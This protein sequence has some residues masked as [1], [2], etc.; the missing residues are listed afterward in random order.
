MPRGDLDA[1][2]RRILVFTSGAHFLTHFFVLVFPALYLARRT[3]AYL[4]TMN[5]G[6]VLLIVIA[7]AWAI[8]R[9][10]DTSLGTDWFMERASVW[11]RQ[12]IPV[13]LAYILG[14]LA[15][16]GDRSND[17]LLPLPSGIEPSE[18]AVAVAEA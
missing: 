17:R 15:Y 12:L 18:P 7:S 4:P 5:V 13:A 6:S 10:F 11:P 9:A 16:S 8:E 14:A 1:N 2:Q 3:R